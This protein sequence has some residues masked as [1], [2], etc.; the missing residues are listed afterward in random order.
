LNDTYSFPQITAYF[1]NTFCLKSDFSFDKNQ[2]KNRDRRMTKALSA[3]ALRVILSALSVTTCISCSNINHAA[4]AR[5]NCLSDFIDGYRNIINSYQYIQDNDGNPFVSRDFLMRELASDCS[6]F[7]E[8]F[9]GGYCTTTQESYG[10]VSYLKTDD[11]LSFCPYVSD[12]DTPTPTPTPSP[13]PDEDPGE[14]K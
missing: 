12:F 6:Q 8:D 9:S 4:D 3:K 2:P 13:D 11:A 10:S 7:E 1:W 5:G 14:T